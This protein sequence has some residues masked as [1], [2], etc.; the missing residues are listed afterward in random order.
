MC[1]K[2]HIK[3]YQ[4]FL[5][6]ESL[7]LMESETLEFKNYNFS[8]EAVDT[9]I[10]SDL[11]NKIYE[12]TIGML[13]N[14]GGRIFVGIKEEEN[15]FLVVGYRFDLKNQDRVRLKFNNGLIYQR[16]I[17]PRVQYHFHI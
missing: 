12:N 4:Y 1:E 15:C 16:Q 7:S 10:L 6:D 3:D 17:D 13:N 8:F 9:P 11:W 14:K 2:P 5:Q